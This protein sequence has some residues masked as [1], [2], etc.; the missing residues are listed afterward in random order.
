M[1]YIYIVVN[2]AFAGCCKVG[3]TTEDNFRHRLTCYQTSDPFRRYEYAYLAMM[4]DP[5]GAEVDVAV[6]F[7]ELLTVPGCEWY[8]AKRTGDKEHRNLIRRII[9]RIESYPGFIRRII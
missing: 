8:K 3:K 4:E 2:S 7:E 1:K 9:T 5:E 6:H